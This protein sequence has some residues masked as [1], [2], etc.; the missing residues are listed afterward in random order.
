[1]IYPVAAEAYILDVVVKYPNNPDGSEAHGGLNFG[2]VKVA[3]AQMK[4][5]VL[6]NKGKYKVGFKFV[7]QTLLV[8]DL[9]VFVPN[10]G[11]IAPKA[12]QKVNYCILLCHFAYLYDK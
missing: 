12:Q 8:H 9:F 2:T 5:L 3:E 7:P 6:E 1:M 10:E 4:P 11:E